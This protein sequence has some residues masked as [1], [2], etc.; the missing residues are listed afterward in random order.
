MLW[1]QFLA[2]AI[3]IALLVRLEAVLI[4]PYWSWLEML[5]DMG[6]DDV[7]RR[8]DRRSA[9]WRRVALPGLI[10]FGLVAVWPSIYGLADVVV[11]GAAAA[12]LLLWPLIFGGLPWGVRRTR[13]ALIYGSL[14]GACAGSSSL[15]WY[16]AEFARSTGG[17][18]EFFEDNLIGIVLGAIVTLYL[19]ATLNRASTA[20][21]K[22][23]GV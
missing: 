23:R 15:G 11:V 8:R 9:M 14:L 22:E 5:S 16:T 18:R 12:G 4:G 19:T 13:L 7:A 2:P 10:A 1:Y 17:F 3:A 21:S 20:A 6:D